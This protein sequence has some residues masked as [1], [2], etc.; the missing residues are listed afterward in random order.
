MKNVQA[1]LR[2]K[3]IRGTGYI[4]SELTEDLIKTRN[5]KIPLGIAM[6]S[7]LQYLSKRYG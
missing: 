5:H 3:R 4:K 2:R 7:E 1:D 6:Y